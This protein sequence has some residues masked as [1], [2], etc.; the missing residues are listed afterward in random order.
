MPANFMRR[1]GPLRGRSSWLPR[2][3]PLFM[4]LPPLLY[5]SIFLTSAGDDEPASSVSTPIA[6]RQ[7]DPR[8]VLSELKQSVRRR[9]VRQTAVFLLQY[10]HIVVTVCARSWLRRSASRCRAQDAA[11][12]SSESGSTDAAPTH[13]PTHAPTPAP[14]PTLTAAPSVPQRER[15]KLQQS[16]VRQSDEVERQRAAIKAAMAHSWKGYRECAAAKPRHVAL[17]CSHQL[18]TSARADRYA[19][20]SDELKPVSRTGVDWMG[21]N[22]RPHPPSR[23]GCAQRRASPCSGCRDGRDDHRLARHVAGDGDG[24]GVP[25]RARLDQDVA[26]F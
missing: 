8:Q 13:A 6:S 19:W 17:R 11:P 7:I 5:I 9:G 14:T 15:V 21:G 12:P 4:L 22:G 10:A 26:E 23:I 18:C 2:L 1:A 3:L 25:P 16:S 20:G 24:G